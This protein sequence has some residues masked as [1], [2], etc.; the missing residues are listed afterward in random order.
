LDARRKNSDKINIKHPQTFRNKQTEKKRGKI[1]KEKFL[2][3]PLD[4]FAMRM[5][6]GIISA[7]KI[8]KEI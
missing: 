4:I 7:C 5:L 6:K 1:H 3:P 2:S 8:K